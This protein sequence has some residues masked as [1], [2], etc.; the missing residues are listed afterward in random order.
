MAPAFDF[1]VL[2]RCDPLRVVVDP[3]PPMDEEPIEPFMPPELIPSELVPLDPMPP[4]A[5]PPEAMPPAPRLPV[6]EP[7][8][9]PPLP[10]ADWAKAVVDSP[11]VATDIASI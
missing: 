10:P 2:L 7:V 5:M 3:V 8:A 11:T 6:E 9:A 1:D 4:E